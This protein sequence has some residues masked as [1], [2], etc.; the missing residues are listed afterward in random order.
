[1]NEIRNFS[2][3]LESTVRDKVTSFSGMV[4]GRAEYM[5]GCRQYLVQPRGGDP[6]KKPE[7]EWFDEARL[8][9]VEDVAEKGTPETGGP[10]ENPAPAK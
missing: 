3:H 2:I 8:L 4:I 1:M 7:S 10:V 9:I 5:T 6:A